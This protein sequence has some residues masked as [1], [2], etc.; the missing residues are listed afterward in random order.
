MLSCYH[1]IEFIMITQ[2][3]MGGCR[4]WTLN[5]FNLVKFNGT[6]IWNIVFRMLE[7]YEMI[8]LHVSRIPICQSHSTLSAKGC[9]KALPLHTAE[10]ILYN[11]CIQFLLQDNS[12]QLF[13]WNL[14]TEAT[15]S[16]TSLWLNLMERER[17]W[18]WETSKTRYTFL[19]WYINHETAP[20]VGS[21][22]WFIS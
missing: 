15:Y 20:S 8:H 13:P 19:S 10:Q 1:A 17:R 11:T 3:P 18:C 22:V 6:E 16:E 12:I 7:I 14:R 21:N 4:Y 2:N 5:S 9:S